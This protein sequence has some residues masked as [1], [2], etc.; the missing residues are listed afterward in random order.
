MIYV[1]DMWRLNPF[2][3]ANDAVIDSSHTLW[4]NDAIIDLYLY[5][6]AE[7]A[8]GNSEI[9]KVHA[10][11]TFFWTLLRK[12]GPKKVENVT[13][14]AKIGG[15]NFLRLHLLLIPVNFDNTHWALG[16]IKPAE[17]RIEFYDSWKGGAHGRGQLFF[18]VCIAPIHGA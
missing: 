8:N 5:M 16:V 10:V 1:D 13:R 12:N 7:R 3:P 4:L 14:K 17:K 11:N 2:P 6:V 9:K 15:D 18:Q